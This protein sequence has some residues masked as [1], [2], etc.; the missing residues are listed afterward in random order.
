METK[1]IYLCIGHYCGSD[2]LSMKFLKV[3]SLENPI[4]LEE[5]KRGELLFSADKK[6]D[7]K[8]GGLY[9]MTSSDEKSYNI[10]F[11]DKIIEITTEQSAES[12]G[13]YQRWK[14]MKTIKSFE[15]KNLDKFLEMKL[16]DVFKLDDFSARRGLKEYIINRL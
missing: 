2:S 12:Q 8:I 3:E 16:K 13:Q 6:K 9:C 4:I 10:K 15:K 1:E 7:Y 5:E 14:S 11:T